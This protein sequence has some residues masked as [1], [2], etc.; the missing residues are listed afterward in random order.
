M[1]GLLANVGGPP[2]AHAYPCGAYFYLP[3]NDCHV[4]PYR[5]RIPR[6]STLTPEEYMRPHPPVSPFCHLSPVRRVLTGMVYLK[7]WLL[8]L[9]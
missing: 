4:S 3:I 7:G 5:H 6:T 1:S 9:I 8:M 2:V